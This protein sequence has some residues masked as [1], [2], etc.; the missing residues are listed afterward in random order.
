MGRVFGDVGVKGRE[1]DRAVHQVGVHAA[2]VWV[3]D[4]L[5]GDKPGCVTR[6]EFYS[7]HKGMRMA[8]VHDMWG[9]RGRVTARD[10]GVQDRAPGS[11]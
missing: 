2:H 1:R 7:V 3:G 5:P 4:V 11:R 10:F 8:Q 9:T 6:N